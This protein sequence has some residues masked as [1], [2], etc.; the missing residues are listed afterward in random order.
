MWYRSVKSG[1]PVVGVEIEY[2]NTALSY[3]SLMFCALSQDVIVPE[4]FSFYAVRAL[5]GSLKLALTPMIFYC[6][7]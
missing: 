4:A 6:L 2:W 5:Y 1:I 3:W 7:L